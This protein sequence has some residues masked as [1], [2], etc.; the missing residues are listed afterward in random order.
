MIIYKI[1]NLV[2]KKIY[3]GQTTGTL[4]KR[5]Q[6]HKQDAISGRLDTHFARAIRKYGEENFSAEIIDTAQ[7]QEELT[8]K[9]YYW[10]GYYNARINGYNETEDL[11]KCGGNT[12]LSKTPE[13][14]EKISSKIRESKLGGKN[15]A[16]KKVKCKST[17][18]GEELFFDSLSECQA[19]FEEKNHNFIT[20]RC[21]GKTKCLYKKEWAIA[22]QENDYYN[23]T[24]YKNSTR[25]QPIEVFDNQTKEK[26]IF[27]S[28][29]SAEKY[30]DVSPH[31]FAANGY[32]EDKSF[33]VG[34]YTITKID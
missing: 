30:Y 25:A 7:T 23:F 16:A 27:P 24:P 29:T 3:I 14:M 15:P 28:Y 5:F 19:Y 22:Y 2:N 6:R 32:R 34:I 33:S 20:R 17:I 8:K 11:F 12:Y 18:T 4:E 13:E 26:K 21:L 1:T 31:L 9:E 10:I